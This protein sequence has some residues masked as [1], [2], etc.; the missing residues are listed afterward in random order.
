VKYKLGDNKTQNGY[1]VYQD[2]TYNKVGKPL[3]VT[4]RYALFQTDSYDSR[5]YGF[6]SDMP[7]SYS[8]PAYYFRGSR[9]YVML[10]YN[11][12]RRIEIWLRYSQTFYDNQ[13]VISPGALTEID[14]NTKSEVRA[15]V[16]FKF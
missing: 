9:F 6:E 1:L 10:D 11:L 14:G 4:L 16:K 3:S 13:T 5:I 12:T 8:I 15:Q 2:V 7:G